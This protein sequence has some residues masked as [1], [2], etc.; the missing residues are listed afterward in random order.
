METKDE[1]KYILTP[2]KN[3]IYYAIEIYS[4]FILYIL[5]FFFRGNFYSTWFTV[6]LWF[7]ITLIILK[8]MNIYNIIIDRQGLTLRRVL[9]KDFKI[10]YGDI[11]KIGLESQGDSRLRT[12]TLYLYS[13]DRIYEHKVSRYDIEA[14]IEIL[15]TKCAEYAIEIDTKDLEPI[16]KSWIW[17]KMKTF[18]MNRRMKKR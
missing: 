12:I 16:R 3:T 18:W 13:Y 1:L 17:S 15:N 6:S 7:V 5:L 8:Q 14:L 4:Y 10:A 11:Q 9:G 2:Y